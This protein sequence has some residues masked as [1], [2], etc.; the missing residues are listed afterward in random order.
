M[1]VV[2]PQ[3]WQEMFLHLPGRAPI[4]CTSVCLSVVLHLTTHI[5]L[6]ALWPSARQVIASTY[7]FV[8]SGRIAQLI[9]PAF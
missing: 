8:R 4:A 3:P 5:M 1:P 2:H 6:T 7:F 9:L